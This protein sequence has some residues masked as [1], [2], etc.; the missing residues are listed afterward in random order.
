MNWFTLLIACGILLAIITVL[1]ILEA[2]CY[3]YHYCKDNSSSNNSSISPDTGIDITKT[4]I[5][6]NNHVIVKTDHTVVKKNTA[7]EYARLMLIKSLLTENHDSIRQHIP[8]HFYS[9]E[10][11][12]TGKFEYHSLIESKTLAVAI[13]VM[14]VNNNPE[15]L[16]ITRMIIKSIEDRELFILDTDI[17]IQPY[18]RLYI[19]WYLQLAGENITEAG[20]SQLLTALAYGRDTQYKHSILKDIVLLDSSGNILP[21]YPLHMDIEDDD[22][23]ITLTAY[24]KNNTAKEQKVKTIAVRN[25]A[26]DYIFA[27]DLEEE[28]IIKPYSKVSIKVKIST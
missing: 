17:Q 14:L 22:Y 7:T 10:N 2:A 3:K 8:I 24:M 11:N 27:Y 20:I 28:L 15:Y 19:V 26:L 23:S 12:I 16:Q 4:G 25:T 1:T 5:S 18:Q 13:R 6:F 9:Q 21:F